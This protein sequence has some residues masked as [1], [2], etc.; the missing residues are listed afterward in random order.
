[1]NHRTPFT[2]GVAREVRHRTLRVPRG[3][4]VPDPWATLRA[5]NVPLDTGTMSDGR[6]GVI[7]WRDAGAFIE[8][9]TV[10]AEDET[11]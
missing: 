3:T 6:G 5:K 11:Q 4:E 10:W 1:M 2:P 7:H 9:V 8:M